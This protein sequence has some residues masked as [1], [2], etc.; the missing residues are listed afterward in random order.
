MMS[1]SNVDLVKDNFKEYKCQEII[2]RRAI[3]S[4]DPSATAKEIIICNY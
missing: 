2:A 1:N 3:N 4:K